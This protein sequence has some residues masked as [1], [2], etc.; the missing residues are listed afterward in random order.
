[1]PRTTAPKSAGKRCKRVPREKPRYRLSVSMKTL[2]T[3]THTII[4][5]IYIHV[6]LYVYIST[7]CRHQKNEIRMHQQQ[8]IL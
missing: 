2:G 6:S 7:K 5:N 1:L 8:N 4:D 3:N